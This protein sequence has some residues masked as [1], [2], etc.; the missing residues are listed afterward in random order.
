MNAPAAT[1]WLRWLGLG[2]LLALTAGLVLWTPE[3]R[4]PADGK[5][6]LRYW[7]VAGA[8]DAVP[9]HARRFNEVQ[10]RI[11][12]E[13]TPIPWQE[14]EKKI[15]TAVLSGDPP[16][17]VSQFVPVVKWAS[18]MALT[19]LDGF[20]GRADFDTT[21]FFPALWDEMKWQ[22]HTFALP[23]NSA[24]YALFYNRALFREA[25]L[26][27]ARPPQT[28]V[29]MEAAA[30]RL[31]RRDARGRL[32]Q[33]GYA[34]TY[35]TLHATQ[36][37]AWQRGARFLSDDGSRV[38]LATPEVLAAFN[39]VRDFY[40]DDDPDAMRAFTS[41]LG[42]GEQHGFLTGKLALAVLDMSYLEQ[43]ARYAPGLDYGVAPIP[44]F[45]DTPTAS[46]AGS[47]WLAI[48]RGA[49]H[50]EAA[51]A[52]MAFAV[53]QQT[54]LQ[55]ALAVGGGLFPSNRHAAADP[56]FLTDSAVGVFVRQMEHAHSPTVVP[57]AHDVFWREFYGAQERVVHGLQTPEAALRQA[58]GVVQSALDRALAYDR[59]VRSRMDA[60]GAG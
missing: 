38:H 54:Q 2:A 11:V 27:P 52:F 3:A 56:R 59:F 39:W 7:Y 16:D 32:V 45:A 14:H 47:W 34:P 57:M 9:Y 5:T 1:V 41:G 60:A 44:R 19:P 58:E 43:I 53:A 50:P 49:R 26:D 10:N 55:E 37:M 40:G 33:V 8:D 35:G 17:V 36:L 13:A 12:V 46:S 24:S 31:T 29:E 42:A 30:R 18:R 51:W 21:A 48:P 6:R 22:G 25:G 15:L 23:I 20:I 4:P 28:W